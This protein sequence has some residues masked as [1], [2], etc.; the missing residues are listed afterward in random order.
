MLKNENISEL[1]SENTL[2]AE[3]KPALIDQRILEILKNDFIEKKSF[4]PAYENIASFKGEIDKYF[5]KVLVM[6]KD[7]IKKN[8]R[9]NMLFE[10]KEVFYQFADFSKLVIDR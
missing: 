6:D 1:S 3:T 4:S 7:E 5:E 8:N 10:I 9:L 2:T